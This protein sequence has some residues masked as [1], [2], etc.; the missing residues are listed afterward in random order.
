[1]PGTGIERMELFVVWVATLAAGTPGAARPVVAPVPGTYAYTASLD[2][3]TEVVRGEIVIALAP[4]WPGGGTEGVAL[5]A[6][7]VNEFV[8]PPGAT[9]GPQVG[10]GTAVGWLRGTEVTL[11]LNPDM[12][13]NNVALAGRIDGTSIVGRWSHATLVGAVAGGPARLEKR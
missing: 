9:V 13:D 6:T 2:D 11:Q 5:E 4:S 3:G 1:M 7:W 12:A 10:R 8:G